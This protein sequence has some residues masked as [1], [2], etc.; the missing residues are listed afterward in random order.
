MTV[1]EARK[2]LEQ[3]ENE[4]F[5]EKP[6]M[7]EVSHQKCGLDRIKIEENGMMERV[8]MVPVNFLWFA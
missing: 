4:G 6:L 8:I 5:G 2:Q 7:I 3:L 1:T